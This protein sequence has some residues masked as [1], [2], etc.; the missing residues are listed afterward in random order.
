MIPV[1]RPLIKKIDAKKVYKVVKDNWIS[2]S[3]PE[4]KIFEN[5]FSKLIG[6]KYGSLVASG[7]AALEIAVKSLKLKKN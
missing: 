4:I 3:G 6:K 7:T 5:K 1:N 2:S